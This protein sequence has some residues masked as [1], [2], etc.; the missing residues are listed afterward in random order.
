MKRA[1]LPAL[2]GTVLL[3]GCVQPA[4]SA[5]Y[6]R[7]FIEPFRARVPTPEE[8]RHE[9]PQPEAPYGLP[10]QVPVTGKPLSLLPPSDVP[11]PVRD[12]VA[13]PVL[14]APAPSL[15]AELAPLV[16]PSAS[17]S[18]SGN[19]PLEGFRPMRGQ[20]RPTP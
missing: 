19:V 13:E 8:T 4:P 3:P 1:L 5:Y 15:P 6:Q 2:L 10:S 7:P 16:A 20:V 14:A 9:P 11:G 17:A 12:R 18:S